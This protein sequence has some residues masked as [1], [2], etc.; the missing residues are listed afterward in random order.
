MVK[1]YLVEEKGEDGKNIFARGHSICKGPLVSRN[2]E[3]LGDRKNTNGAAG[4]EAEGA[5][6]SEQEHLPGGQSAFL[7]LSHSSFPQVKHKIF[8]SGRY[9]VFQ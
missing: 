6:E 9:C 1:S 4:G 5:E 3:H 2:I 7:L 8:A